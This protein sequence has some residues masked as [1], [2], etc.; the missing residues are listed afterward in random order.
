[1]RRGGPTIRSD[2]LRIYLQHLLQVLE[3]LRSVDYGALMRQLN[4]FKINTSRK[5]RHSRIAFIVNN[6]KPTR[7]NTSAISIFKPPRI[8]T[9]KKHG[10]VG[11]GALKSYLRFSVGAAGAV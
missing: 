2:Q 6:F 9:S 11:W 1:M 5:L 4:P 10:G 3:L 7:I 8:N